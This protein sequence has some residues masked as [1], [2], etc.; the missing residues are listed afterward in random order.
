MDP[1]R[2]TL[3]RQQ[4][5]L[6]INRLKGARSMPDMAEEVRAGL[7]ARPKR[8]PP[9]YFYDPHGSWLFERICTT[10]EYYPTRVEEAILARK[11]NAIIE[12]A[13]PD[14]IVELGSGA[15]RKTVHLLDACGRQECTPRYQPMDV[16][17]DI[18]LQ[19][20]DRLLRR[21]PWLVIEPLAGDYCAGLRHLPASNGC[22]R[23]FVFLGGTIGNFSDGEALHFLQDVRASMN[24]TDWFLLGADR[25]KDSAVLNAAYND[26]MGY[27]AEFNLN[28]LRVINRELNA[29]FSLDAFRHRAW[30]NKE[31]AQVEM[32]LQALTA[33]QAHI[34]K[35][36]MNVSFTRGETIRTEISRKFT[37]ETLSALVRRAGF[38][39]DRHYE[40]EDGCFSLMLLRPATQVAVGRRY[41]Q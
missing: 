22:A 5:R 21:Y 12:R 10:P 31:Q 14:C 26:A 27:T 29:D 25:I 8:L 24:A 37:P 40:P 9:K 23:L 4:K 7:C 33:H 18:L 34:Y 38:D 41:H 20:G 1:G 11:A 19:A 2:T 17:D 6:K 3:S 15:S 30:Y 13:Q 36:S 32:H 35:L 16:C 28:V 39:I